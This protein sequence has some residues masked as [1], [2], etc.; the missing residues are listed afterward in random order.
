MT[1]ILLTMLYVSLGF[2]TKAGIDEFYFKDRKCA[3]K[4]IFIWAVSMASLFLALN[5]T[6]LFD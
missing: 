1:G 3:K 6:I 4:D 5:Q 2:L